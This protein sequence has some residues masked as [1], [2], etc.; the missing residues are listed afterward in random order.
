MRPS[1]ALLLCEGR[2]D[3][4]PRDPSLRPR[5]E[6]PASWGPGLTLVALARDGHPGS[7][8]TSLR[9]AGEAPPIQQTS[10]GPLPR[11]PALPHVPTCV[12]LPRQREPW[13]V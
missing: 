13:D 1:L 11:S 2:E 12:S 7:R 10:P 8:D 6:D 5:R 4:A 9:S 3:C